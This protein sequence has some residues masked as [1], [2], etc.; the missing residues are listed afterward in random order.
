ML[1]DCLFLAN[2]LQA[3][4]TNTIFQT[5]YLMISQ[6]WFGNHESG[7]PM[8]TLFSSA[9]KNVTLVFSLNRPFVFCLSCVQTLLISYLMTLFSIVV[10]SVLVQSCRFIKKCVVLMGVE[11][12]IITGFILHIK[13]PKVTLIFVAQL[14]FSKN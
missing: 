14:S 3:L 11:T 2:D 4:K 8:G 1:Q 6:N 10:K 7:L 9:A 13:Y 5:F 12:T